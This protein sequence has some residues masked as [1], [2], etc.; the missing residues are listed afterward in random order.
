MALRGDWE[1]EG[2]GGGLLSPRHPTTFRRREAEGASGRSQRG[3][4]VPLYLALTYFCTTVRL[5][6]C[7]G[8]LMLN[9][10]FVSHE[11]RQRT[12]VCHAAAP[13]PLGSRERAS[14]C[15]AHRWGG[16]LPPNFCN[17]YGLR[18]PL[19]RTRPLRLTSAAHAPASTFCM[20]LHL[21]S[22]TDPPA[23]PDSSPAP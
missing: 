3:W 1:R 19:Y 8:P 17:G 2:A 20:R 15:C 6:A 5:L 7:A 13:A 22:R 18:H 11:C 16:A 10:A 21:G 14:R 12:R 9:P 23:L 4:P